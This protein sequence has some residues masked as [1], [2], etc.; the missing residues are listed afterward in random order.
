MF[1]KKK[2]IVFALIALAVV[3]ATVA[4]GANRAK[5]KQKSNLRLFKREAYKFLARQSR[6]VPSQCQ[7]EG[8]F[9]GGYNEPSTGTFKFAE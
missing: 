2:K 5:S 1:P 7:A 4:G 3:I 6:P 8:E 9:C